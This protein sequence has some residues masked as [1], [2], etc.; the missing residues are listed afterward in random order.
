MDA[1]RRRMAMM[2]KAAIL[3][4]LVVL[5]TS[6]A[7]SQQAAQGSRQPNTLDIRDYLLSHSPGVDP[8]ETVDTVKIGDPTRPVK[9]A[10]VCWYPSIETIKAAHE[11]GCDLLICHEPT[12]WEHAAPELSWRDKPPGKAKREFLEKSGMVVLRVHDTWDRWPEVGILDSWARFLGLQNPKPVPPGDPFRA[13]YQIRPQKLRDFARDIARR[14]KPLGEDSVQVMGDP[15]RIVRCPAL[16]VGC[17]SPDK[18]TVDA[19]A[20]VVIVCYD[21]ASYWQSRERLHEMGA[22]V[23][24]LEHGTTE[25]PGIEN[26]CR[27]LAEKFPQVQ[28]QYL[29]RHPRPWTVRAE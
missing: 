15:D 8:K 11:A 9:K 16:G 22:A 24:T 28:F 2:T 1:A 29:A 7:A 4:A 27:H 3:L 18:E 20:D 26:L 25:M 19:G 14:V 10:G 6:W 17:I 13:I 5:G 12:F 21:G 23:I